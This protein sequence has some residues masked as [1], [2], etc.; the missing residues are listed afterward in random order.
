[1]V[2]EGKRAVPQ[3][4]NACPVTFFGEVHP[5]GN[6][7]LAVRHANRNKR[8]HER[9]VVRQV[10][11]VRR[12]RAVYRVDVNPVDAPGAVGHIRTKAA[13]VAIVAEVVH[14]SECGG[15]ARV[16]RIARREAEVDKEVR[17][18]LHHHSR[19]RRRRRGRKAGGVVGEEHAVAE[20]GDEPDEVLRERVPAGRGRRGRAEHLDQRAED[21]LLLAG[22]AFG[23]IEQDGARADDGLQRAL[24]VDAFWRGAM[25]MGGERTTR[26]VERLG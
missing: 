24:P 22:P 3:P 9:L 20:H 6:D 23:R 12:D 1:M 14:E 21:D 16:R 4:F 7:A 15:L 26:V 13:L 8:E 17:A 25:E 19:R 5:G 10:D 18:H 11:E 2:D